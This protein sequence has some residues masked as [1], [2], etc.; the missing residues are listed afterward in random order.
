MK[1]C[2]SSLPG[3]VRVTIVALMRVTS[4]PVSGRLEMAINRCPLSS[5]VICFTPG[6]SSLN[7]TCSVRRF[8]MRMLP[9]SADTMYL[10]VWQKVLQQ[11]TRVRTL[12]FQHVHSLLF[13]NFQNWGSCKKKKEHKMC[14]TVSLKFF[15]SIN[16]QCCYVWDVTKRNVCCKASIIVFWFQ[17]LPRYVNE[18][19]L[20]CPFLNVLKIHSVVLDRQMNMAKLL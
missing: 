9:D 18:S 3:M 7:R 8:Q 17:L 5:R 19:I 10:T 14:F 11:E 2:W 20:N 12:K 4:A 6:C 15:S 13:N 16:V 1:N